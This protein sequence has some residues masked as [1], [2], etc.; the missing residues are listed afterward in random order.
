[1]AGERDSDNI[2]NLREAYQAQS[3]EQISQRYDEWASDYETNMANVGYAHPAVVAAML[4]R[5]LPPG[6]EAILDAGAGTGLLSELLSALGYSHLVGIDA[7]Q[8]MLSRAKAKGLYRE[9]RKMFI[10]DALDFADNQFAAT[11]SAGVFTEGHAPLSGL[12]DL[13]R[14]TRPGGYLI[15]SIARVYLEETFDAKQN[16]REAQGRWRLVDASGRYNSTPLEG[17]IPARVF[18]FQIT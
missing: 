1:M 15:F 17:E 14:V 6:D 9:L 13:I 7:S 18:V 11:V 3:P 8:Q 16:A 4:A 10:G 5:H 12:D 2:R